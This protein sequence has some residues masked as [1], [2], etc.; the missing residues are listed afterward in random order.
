MIVE[1]I[2]SGK[3]FNIKMYFHIIIPQRM[4]FSAGTYQ[5][6]LQWP[7]N[8]IVH[9]LMKRILMKVSLLIFKSKAME[10]ISKPYLT[11]WT[12]TVEGLLGTTGTLT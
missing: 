11:S 12:D 1:R 10:N 4:N 6:L 7:E 3:L 8:K 5:G 2:H 9:S